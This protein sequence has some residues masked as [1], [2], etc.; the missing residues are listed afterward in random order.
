MN[1]A[2]EVIEVVAYAKQVGSDANW[3][4]TAGQIASID[5]Y[6]YWNTSGT[7]LV[8]WADTD[9]NEAGDGWVAF[10]INGSAASLAAIAML[11]DPSTISTKQLFYITDTAKDFEQFSVQTGDDYPGTTVKIPPSSETK[12]TYT[13]NQ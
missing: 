3:E 9:G 8:A 10:D 11:D 12:V 4:L 2:Y 7:K 13:G 1:L 6:L 5:H